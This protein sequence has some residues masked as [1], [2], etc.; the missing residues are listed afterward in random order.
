MAELTPQTS[1]IQSL[2]SMYRNG[3]IH[4]NRRYQR[5]LVWTLIEKQKLI[6]SI[7]KKYPIP[8]VLLAERDSEPESYEIIDGLQRLQAILSFVETSFPTSDGKFFHVQSFPTAMKHASNNEFEYNQNGPFITPD[9]VSIILDYTLSLSVM[10][11]ASDSEINDV[12]GR[13][14]TYGHRLSDQERRQAGVQNQFSEMVRSIS[15]TLRGDVSQTILPLSLMPSISIDLPKT[16]HGYQIQAEEVFWVNQGILRSTD[17]RDSMDEQCIADIAASIIGGVC[18]ER[19]KEA[20]D[21]IYNLDDSESERISNALQIYG[22]GKF[23]KE[24][25]FC[26]N[27]IIQMCNESGNEKLREILFGKKSNNAFPSMFV[28]V[29][30]AFHELLIKD[31]KKISDY[32][33]IKNALQKLSN[34]IERGR[35]VASKEERKKNIDTVKGLIQTH[36]IPND[37]NPRSFI[38][39]TAPDIDASIR[40]SMIELPNYEL[41]QGILTLLIPRKIDPNIISKLVKTIAAIANNGPDSSGGIIIG[42]ADTDKDAERIETLDGIKPI[43]VGNRSV[44]GINRE[45]KILNISLEKYVGYIKDEIKKSLLT[46]SVK[47]S[48]LSALGYDNYFGLGIITINVP[49]QKEMAFVNDEV[50]WRSGDSTEKTSDPKRIAIIAQRFR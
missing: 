29:F 50:Y 26:V 15:C 45:A 33:G 44:V 28:I 24:F 4:V 20:L 8:A 6:E 13:I 14:N 47:M 17:L 10:R 5:K 9:E 11:S 7:M 18:L 25:S 27:E 48:V 38:G 21:K 32:L 22:T 41:K 34:R 31:N 12:F 36:F 42:V 16:K 30:M 3:K 35:S 43:I 40:R 37:K 46:D 2:Y 1:S 19:S 23:E 39:G 49:P